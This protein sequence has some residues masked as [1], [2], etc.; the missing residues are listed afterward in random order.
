MF[1]E[2]KQ[3][4]LFGGFMYLLTALF[5][6][7]LFIYFDNKAKVKCRYCNVIIYRRDNYCAMCGKKQW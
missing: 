3:L 2:S 5:V 1:S 6:M 7:W 4:F